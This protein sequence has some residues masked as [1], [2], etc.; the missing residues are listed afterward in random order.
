[1]IRKKTSDS[2]VKL[3]FFICLYSF[4][5][6]MPKS[7]SLPSLFAHSIFFKEQLEGF[8]PV[9]QVSHDKRATGAILSFYERIALFMSGSLFRSFAHKNEQIAGKTD[10]QISNPVFSV[11]L[12]IFMLI[13]PIYENRAGYVHYF[14]VRRYPHTEFKLSVIQTCLELCMH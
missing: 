1:M 9:A 3:V 6:F 12:Y 5:P 11:P 10:E 7:E 4:F 8:S 2:P 14:E 13:C